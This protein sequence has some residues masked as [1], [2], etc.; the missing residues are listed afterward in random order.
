MCT[1]S[2]AFAGRERFG[3]N[4]DAA[5]VANI[6]DAIHELAK[7][8]PYSAADLAKSTVQHMAKRNGKFPAAEREQQE[9][10]AAAVVYFVLQVQ[11]GNCLP[12]PRPG[13]RGPP[14]HS[15]IP[16]S[17]PSLN[18]VTLIPRKALSLIKS[19][20]A[21]GASTAAADANK[22]EALASMQQL[23]IMLMKDG[24]DLNHVVLKAKKKA[25]GN[26]HVM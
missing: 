25:N 26:R 23:V 7:H 13:R 9:I 18:K 12:S 4:G 8:R 5:E 17:P 15:R 3:W 2:I 22:H 11:L 19:A 20:A 10:E 21:S 16:P 24:I 6:E 14:S 1:I